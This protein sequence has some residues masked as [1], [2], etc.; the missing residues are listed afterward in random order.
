VLYLVSGFRWSFYGIADVNPA[1]QPRDDHAF[2]LAIC[3]ATL[4]L[5]VQD[6]LSA[7]QLIGQHRLRCG[8]ADDIGRST[9]RETRTILDFAGLMRDPF[10]LRNQRCCDGSAA[11]RF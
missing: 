2:F 4:W 11:L 8:S 10:C 3:L 6:G 5:D 9:R 7:A 1:D